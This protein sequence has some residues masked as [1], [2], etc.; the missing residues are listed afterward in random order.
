MAES[1]KSRIIVPKPTTLQKTFGGDNT[2]T[3]AFYNCKKQSYGS[4]L[5]VCLIFLALAKSFG[6][7][8]DDF[9][10]LPKTRVCNPR[11]AGHNP[12]LQASQCGPRRWQDKKIFFFKSI[13]LA[14]CTV[15]N[16]RV[17]F[18]IL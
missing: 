17:V 16:T 2:G 6:S 10:R 18:S 8:Q 11:P 9:C 5:T 13:Y 1:H 12:A 15:Y 7:S 4:N 14:I 3:L